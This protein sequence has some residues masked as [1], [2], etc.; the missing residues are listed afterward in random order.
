MLN[1]K[2]EAASYLHLRFEFVIRLITL[3]NLI[4]P[5]PRVTKKLQGQGIDAAKEYCEVC[6][7]GMEVIRR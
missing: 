2:N 1:M 4:Q 5:L 6:I 7:K 3:N